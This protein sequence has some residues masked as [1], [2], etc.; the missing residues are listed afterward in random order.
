MMFQDCAPIMLVSKASLEAVNKKL[1]CP[2]DIRTFR[3][4][5]YVEGCLPYEEDFWQSVQIGKVLLRKLRQTPRYIN[6]FIFFVKLS[7]LSLHKCL[8]VS[9]IDVF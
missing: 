6:L 4:N 2:V 7:C 3:P 1:D 5:I 9:F 8:F